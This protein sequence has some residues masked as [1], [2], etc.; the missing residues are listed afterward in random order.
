MAGARTSCLPPSLTPTMR[1]RRDLAYIFL[2]TS[3]FDDPS[4]RHQR[5]TLGTA[6]RKSEC[7]GKCRPGHA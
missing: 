6:A 1:A 7:K 5:W 3:S 2:R 4:V